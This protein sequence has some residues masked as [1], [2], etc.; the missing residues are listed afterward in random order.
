VLLW[1]RNQKLGRGKCCRARGARRVKA[2]Q[3][4]VHAH[5][6][7]SVVCLGKVDHGE[8]ESVIILWYRRDE[9]LRQPSWKI[10]GLQGWRDQDR[11][12]RGESGENGRRASG[13]CPGRGVQVSTYLST[14]PQRADGAGRAEAG[15]QSEG[16]NGGQRQELGCRR[17]WA[18]GGGAASVDRMVKSARW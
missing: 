15:C 14:G 10:A 8:P 16:R 9:V 5:E 4:L 1:S 2:E 17:G 3:R 12:G 11:S 13:A 6:W 18:H 7:V